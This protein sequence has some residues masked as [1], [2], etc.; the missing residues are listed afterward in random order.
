LPPL[1]TENAAR[2]GAVTSGRVFFPLS[3]NQGVGR[4]EDVATLAD[5]ERALVARLRGGDRAA[6]RTLYAR[7]AQPSFGFLLRLCG[8]RE[9]AEDLH[10]ETWL[11]VARHATRLAADSDVAAWI[12]TIA[13]NQFRSAHRSAARARVP[14]A[15]AVETGSAGQ[16]DPAAH[17]LERALGA[18]PEAHREILLLVGVEGLAVEQAAAVLSLRPDAARQRLARARAALAARLTADA[19]DAVPAERRG[20]R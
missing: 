6:F 11:A 4:Y 5:D 13:R 19:A 15:P 20:A 2:A 7:Y 1:V 16:D 8:R 9:L 18:L 17:D 14:E 3:Q 10:Q 12:F